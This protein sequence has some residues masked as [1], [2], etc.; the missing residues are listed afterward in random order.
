ME[1]GLVI[2]AVEIVAFVIVVVTGGTYLGGYTGSSITVSY[3]V[4]VFKALHQLLKQKAERLAFM[5]S[6]YGP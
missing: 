2:V 6:Q 5:P 4:I 1:A 3:G